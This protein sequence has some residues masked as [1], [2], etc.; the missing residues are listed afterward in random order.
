MTVREPTEPTGVGSRPRPATLT[1]VARVAGVAP[2][3]VSRAF[4]KPGRVNA[5]TCEHVLR[6]AAELGYRPNPAARALESGRTSTLGL[7]V[8]DITNPHFFALVRGAERQASTAGFT[9]L[10]GDTQQSPQTERTVVDRIHASVDGLILAASRLPPAE[11]RAYAATKPLVLI[12][13]QAEDVT[14]VVTDHVDGP[15]QIVEHLHSLGHRALVFLSGPRES[16]SG[17]QRWA[18]IRDTAK[19]LGI[20]ATRLGPFPPSMAGGPAAA[21]A[22]IGTAATAVIAHNDLLAIGALRRFSDRG[23]AVP[24]DISVVGFDDIF[25]ADFCAPPLTTL[26]GPL[27]EA[28]RKAV[29]IL[30]TQP[31]ATVRAP[32]FSLPSHLKIRESTGPARPRA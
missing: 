20:A 10:L 24:G 1:D 16:W 5:A 11:L 29:E 26:T 17:A 23:L 13:R 25:G 21:D 15:R 14:S 12:N 8:S 6:V 28:G 22:A 27:D 7:V 18:V 9:L 2:S 3:T 4:T 19:S 31:E 32:R 30:V